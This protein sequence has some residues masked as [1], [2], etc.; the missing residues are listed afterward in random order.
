MASAISVDIHARLCGL[1]ALANALP[2]AF[3][4]STRRDFVPRWQIGFYSSK[5]FQQSDR[6]SFGIGIWYN[7]PWSSI[8]CSDLI[9]AKRSLGFGERALIKAMRFASLKG[10]GEVDRATLDLRQHFG[11]VEK[12][13]LSY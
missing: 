9:L 10:D 8:R 4:I 13:P 7:H 6:L 12:R 1:S 5:N 11:R 2:Y 3:S